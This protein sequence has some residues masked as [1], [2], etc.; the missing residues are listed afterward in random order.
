MLELPERERLDVVVEVLARLEGAPDPDWE[1]AWL[2]ALDRRE[3]A[4]SAEPTADEDWSAAR[5]RILSG[6]S[7]RGE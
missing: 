1:A 4:E 3:Q 7:S 2:A 5:A 6:S